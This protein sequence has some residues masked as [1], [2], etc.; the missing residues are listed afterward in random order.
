MKEKAAQHKFQGGMIDITKQDYEWHC[1]NMPEDTLGVILMYQDYI[2]ES[3]MLKQCLGE[4][5][6]KHPTRKFM[7]I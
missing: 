1:K 7:Q 6:K 5:A 2:K 3:L 4:L